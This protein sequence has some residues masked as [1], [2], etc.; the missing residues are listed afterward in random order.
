MK[1]KS[2]FSYLFIIC[3]LFSFQLV[4]KT[5][6]STDNLPAEETTYYYLA[7]LLALLVF[8]GI[9]YIWRM[10]R[11]KRVRELLDDYFPK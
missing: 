6:S 1:R 4:Q 5:S 3:L 10:K 7:S 8:G 9:V 2:V 11:R